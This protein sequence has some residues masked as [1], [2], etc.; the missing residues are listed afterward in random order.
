M[1]L[2]EGAP[3]QGEIAAG[4][5]RPWEDLAEWLRKT[6]PKITRMKAANEP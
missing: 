4:K 3:A 1:V 6:A 2:Q 5:S